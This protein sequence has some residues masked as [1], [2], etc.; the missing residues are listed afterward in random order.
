MPRVLRPPVSKN[1]RNFSARAIAPLTVPRD[2]PDSRQLTPGFP[3]R[4]IA[5][6]NG[7]TFEHSP[8]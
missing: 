4:S 5:T 1:P 6:A 3:P 8:G 2:P 7:S